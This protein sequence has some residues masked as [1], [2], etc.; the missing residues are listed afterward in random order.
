MDL[1]KMLN[2]SIRNRVQC[3]CSRIEARGETLWLVWDS[4]EF[5]QESFDDWHDIRVN[6]NF[7]RLAERAYALGFDRLTI[8]RP[9]GQSWDELRITSESHSQQGRGRKS[10]LNLERK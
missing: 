10:N 9:D 5:T 2:E 7:W 1:S 4:S 6:D 3:P 8:V